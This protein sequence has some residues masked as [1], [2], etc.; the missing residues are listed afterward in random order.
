MPSVLNQARESNK[1]VRHFLTSM[2]GELDLLWWG[3]ARY[4]E[5]L[6]KPFRRIQPPEDVLWWAA[7]EAADRAQG[8]DVEPAAAYLVE[9]LHA[10]GQDASERRS[11]LQWMEGLHAS[12]NRAPQ[13]VP[14]LS[15]PLERYAREDA[16]GLPVTWV[17]LQAARKESLEGAAE[18]VALDLKAEIDRGQWASWILREC[19]L[20]LHLAD[21]S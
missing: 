1:F 16:L 10:L 17:R 8:V 5:S 3:Q 13:L 7:R 15:E 12:L 19:L 4:C 20:D 11:L 2:K 6:R 9:T 18:K 14:A 21:R